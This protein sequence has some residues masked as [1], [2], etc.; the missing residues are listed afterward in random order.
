[1]LI[2]ISNFKRQAGISLLELMLSLAIIAV[3]LTMATRFY[4]QANQNQNLNNAVSMVNGIVAATHTY[5]LNV[6]TTG[7]PTITELIT[8]GQLPSDFGGTNPWG[9]AMTLTWPTTGTQ[10]SVVFGSIPGGDDATK[11]GACKGLE[12]RLTP[13]YPGTACKAGTVTVP[14]DP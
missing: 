2:K 4:T 5:R 3:V 13:T 1:M 14:F 8:A 11:G 12:S 9:G 10:G 7:K 6:S